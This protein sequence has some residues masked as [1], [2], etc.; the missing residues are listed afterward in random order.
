MVNLGPRKA[1]AQI[2]KIVTNGTTPNEEDNEPKKEGASATTKSDPN[3][4]KGLQ[5]W[6]KD[7]D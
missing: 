7:V 6:R 2:G 3:Q 4:A 1:R 5:R